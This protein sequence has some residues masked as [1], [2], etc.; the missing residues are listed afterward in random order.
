MFFAAQFPIAKLWSQ[1]R[2]PPTEEW[3]KKMRCINTMEYDPAIKKS[4][5]MAFTGKWMEV[6]MIVLSGIS[7][8]DKD[9]GHSFSHL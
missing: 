7:H 9:E 1:A 4:G 6:E 2:C 8:Y 3:I 5:A